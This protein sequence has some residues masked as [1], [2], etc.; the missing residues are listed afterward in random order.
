[1]YCDPIPNDFMELG[2]QS[3]FLG[4]MSQVEMLAM[5]LSDGNDTAKWRLKDTAGVNFGSGFQHGRSLLETQLILA[6]MGPDMI[7]RR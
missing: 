4:I 1:M 5:F 6:M 2:T 7:C 3:E